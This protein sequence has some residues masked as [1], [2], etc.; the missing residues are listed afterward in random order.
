MEWCQKYTLVIKARNS[1][2]SLEYPMDL[3]NDP[4]ITIGKLHS[5]HHGYCY[6]RNIWQMGNLKTELMKAK[7]FK[8]D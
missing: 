4:Y 3:P 1:H 5:A 6:I 8:I 2:Y 7:R